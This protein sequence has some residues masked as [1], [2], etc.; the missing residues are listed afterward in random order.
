VRRIS[1]R[2]SFGYLS[3]SFC[4][5]KH[6]SGRRLSFAAATAL[7][8]NAAVVTGDPEFKKLTKVVSVEWL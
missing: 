5:T 1:W 6:S 4:L 8:Q 7:I 2:I 3:L